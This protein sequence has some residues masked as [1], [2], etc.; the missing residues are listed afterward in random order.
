M[1]R[2]QI[3]LLLF[4]F[5]VAYSMVSVTAVAHVSH[6]HENEKI[7]IAK[8]SKIGSY[9]KNVST[10]QIWLLDNGYYDGEIDG[11]FGFQTEEA[12]ENLQKDLGINVDG[13]IGSQTK[14]SIITLNLRTNG[15]PPAE[16]DKIFNL[17]PKDK[18]KAYNIGI[19]HII[20]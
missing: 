5:F 14:N 11:L 8:N 16:S 15:N 18:Y 20:R 9:G 3:F 6:A 7:A 4:I 13:I 1:K 10:L 17:D 12:V 19:T 2:N